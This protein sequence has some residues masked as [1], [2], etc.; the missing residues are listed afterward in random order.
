MQT[1]TIRREKIQL[2]CCSK[3]QEKHNFV[4]ENSNIHGECAIAC[5]YSECG[6]RG[7]DERGRKPMAHT[8]PSTTRSIHH[9]RQVEC[10][11]T[12]LFLANTHLVEFARVSC[13]RNRRSAHL[14]SLGTRIHFISELELHLPVPSHGWCVVW[15]PAEI[16]DSR[17]FIRA[18]KER[19]KRRVNRF[20]WF[21]AKMADINRIREKNNSIRLFYS[22]EV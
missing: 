1:C 5:A 21:A 10:V 9:C 15:I 3:T 17:T 8:G 22:I 11:P 20:N 4:K 13:R 16:P 2:C 6:E 12:S 14:L 7:R 19:W 18:A